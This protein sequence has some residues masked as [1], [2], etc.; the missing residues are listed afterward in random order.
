MV[1]L[2]TSLTRGVVE[3][4]TQIS[5]VLVKP[6]THVSLAGACVVHRGCLA[7]AAHGA[8]SLLLDLQK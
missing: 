3:A 6:L 2:Q 4:L 8:A 7:A 5:L 1:V